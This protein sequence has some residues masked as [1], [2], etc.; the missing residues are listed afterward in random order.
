MQR[1]QVCLLTDVELWLLAPQTAHRVG[2]VVDGA[3]QA[4]LDLPASEVLDDGPGVGQRAG[5]TVELGD[6]EGVAG[7]A[8]GQSLAQSG[9]VPVGPGQALVDVGALG[10]DAE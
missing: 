1:D 3:A 6:D 9:P 8:G 4:E 7:P 10:T 5:Q 2:G